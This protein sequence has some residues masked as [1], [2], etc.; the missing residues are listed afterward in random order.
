MEEEVM[1]EVEEDEEGG[2]A[3]SVLRPQ[4]K[5]EQWYFPRHYTRAGGCNL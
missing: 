1:M 5:Q 4:A 2:R 3:D